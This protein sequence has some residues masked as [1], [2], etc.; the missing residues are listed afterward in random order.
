MTTGTAQRRNP[1]FDMLKGVAI[2]LVVMGHV[3]IFGM[4]CDDNYIPFRI[5][6][7]VHMPLFFFISGWF[8]YK[9]A[10]GKLE[11]PRLLKRFN[12]LIIPTVIVGSAFYF[13]SPYSDIPE[14]P[15]PHYIGMWLSK[16][17]NGYWFGIT[18]FMIMVVYRLMCP[19]FR[20]I[21]MGLKGGIL[22]LGVY[23]LLSGI[24]A[25]S[26]VV[27][28]DPLQLHMLSIY[29]VPFIAG[30]FARC[31]RTRF[32]K[33]LSSSPVMTAVIVVFALSLAAVVMRPFCERLLHPGQIVFRPLLHVSL[34]MLAICTFKN[35]GSEPHPRGMLSLWC[36]LGRNSLGI[37]LLHYFFIFSIPFGADILAM[38][39]GII[40]A[41][42]AAA[43]GAAL[44][45]LMSMAVILLLKPSK[46]LSKLFCGAT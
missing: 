37:Y 44:V 15:C 28:S 33:A 6:G 24:Y 30:V 35:A 42:A 20:R 2:Y 13:Y 3:M 43:V 34:A 45:V 19:L 5:V 40:P 14:S 22:A 4:H 46:I 21:G 1:L 7:A 11:A 32:D 16:L 39:A 27:V 25:V 38:S 8:S 31:H 41:Y 18:L 29:Y 23:I 12:Q 26:P 36:A 17:K 10:E 9:F